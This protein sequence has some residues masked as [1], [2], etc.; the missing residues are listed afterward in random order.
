MYSGRRCVCPL[1]D[2]YMLDIKTKAVSQCGSVSLGVN[3]KMEDQMMR[4]NGIDALNGLLIGGLLGIVLFAGGC[5]KTNQSPNAEQAKNQ[6]PIVEQTK[7]QSPNA[8]QIKAD[9]FNKT[10]SLGGNKLETFSS[11]A[12][13][14]EVQI[15]KENKQGDVIE[16][17]VKI[18]YNDTTYGTSDTIEAIIIYK[19][20][21]GTWKM[22]SSSGKLIM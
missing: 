1:N 17:K 19:Q 13:F 11:L 16:Y 20:V 9:L 5:S 6:P 7:N 8:E 10:I 18:V 4:K 3:N 15:L 22:V 21:E 12:N 2:Q 14:K